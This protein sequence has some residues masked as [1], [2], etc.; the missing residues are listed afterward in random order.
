MAIY[1]GT[2]R[3]DGGGV[4]DSSGA[5]LD[6]NISEPSYDEIIIRDTNNK[7]KKANLCIESI[8]A[9]KYGDDY[10]SM[11]KNIGEESDSRTPVG[12]MLA[13]GKNDEGSYITLNKLCGHPSTT[14]HNG[15]YDNSK[16]SD[17]L[18][19]SGGF[20]IGDTDN[21]TPPYGS[22]AF[23]YPKFVI[24]FRSYEMVNNSAQIEV[25]SPITYIVDHKNTNSNLNVVVRVNTRGYGE[26]ADD[27]EFPNCGLFP[28]Q[29]AI[30]C[31][32]GNK[33]VN[34]YSSLYDGTEG[35]V[36][37]SNNFNSITPTGSKFICY[38]VM[39]M[40]DGDILV[41]ANDYSMA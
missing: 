29:C 27:G 35:A 7:I 26:M 2:K 36:Y 5:I 12:I 20:I 30:I 13:A 39:A 33:S 11:I 41:N 9:N 16:L 28:G 22:N 37:Y 14:F 1:I 23:D 40:E 4:S 31:I 25:F 10:I 32:Y 24:P 34:F 19:T 8:I 38:G 21:G 18:I 15:F 17:I 3:I 6:Y